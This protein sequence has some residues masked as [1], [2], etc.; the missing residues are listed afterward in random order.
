MPLALVPW[1]PPLWG[2]GGMT[3]QRYA[4]SLGLFWRTSIEAE[5]E[6]QLNMLLEL[7]SVLGNLAGS[8]FVLSLLFSGEN[9][10]GG[11][12]WHEAL[13]VLGIYTLLDGFTSCC[14]QPNLSKIVNHVQ[15][16]TLDFVLLKPIDS[17]FWLS[18]RCLSPWGIPAL[19]M[20]LSLISLGLLKSA[21]GVQLESLLLGT[22]L[23][24]SGALILYSLWFALA[25]LSIWFVK[26]WNATEVLR[27][28]L[29]AG[30]YPLSAYPA[31]L[32]AV[33]TFVLPVAFMTTVPSQA[34]LGSASLE[35]VL[36]SLTAAAIS[37]LGSRLFWQY[38][39]RHYTSASS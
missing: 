34:L 6:Y 16:G 5:T 11:W 25:A 2:H 30:R 9:S 33:F 17:Q 35:W 7:L 20:G 13:V 26:V 14:L 31:A 19:L 10:L 32:R 36:G 3:I 12:S 8:L 4:R 15:Q 18:F 37:L 29:V 38:A 23:L 22:A 39:L 1:H 28:T 27:Y 24:M 21:R